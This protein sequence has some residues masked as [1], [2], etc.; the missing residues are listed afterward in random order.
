MCPGGDLAAVVAAASLRAG[1]SN[2]FSGVALVSSAKSATLAPR[3]PG[4]V[5]LCA[6]GHGLFPGSARRPEKM[7]I[8]SPSATDTIARLVSGRRPHRLS[9]ALLPWLIVFTPVT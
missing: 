5:G 8:R 9:T 2:D 1:T 7:S 4:V 3:R 6:D